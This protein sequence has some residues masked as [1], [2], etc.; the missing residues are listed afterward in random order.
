[1]Q[2]A[3]EI[4]F[5]ELFTEQERIRA[6]TARFNVVHGGHE[7]GKSTLAVDT[8]LTSQYGALNGYP[9]GLFVPDADALLT[10]KRRVFQVVQPL[11]T[12]RL[13]RSRVDLINGGS[14][15]FFSLDAQI[16]ELWDQLALVVV[17]DA[18]LVP[19]IHDIWSDVLEPMLAKHRG[20]AWFFSKPLGVRNGFHEI[21]R[22][23]GSDDRWATFQLRASDNPYLDQT[24]VEADRAAMLPEVFAQERD[25]EFIS[26]PIE[27]SAGQTLIGRDE[28][29]RQW[30]NRLAADGLKV[31]GH[32]FTLDDRPAMWF[33]YDLIPSTIEDAYE[34]MVVMMKCSQVGFTIMELLAQIYMALKFMPA[35]VGLYLP[36]QNLARIKSSQRFVPLLRTIPSAY[37]LMVDPDG[38]S[39]RAGEGNVMIRNLGSSS[40]YFLWTSGKGATESVPLDLLALDEVQ[41]MQV[42]DMEKVSERLSAS[43][44]KFTMAGSTANW[45]D[46]DIHY[47]YQR[48]TMHQFW[49]RCR[50]C[51]VSHV[52]DEHFPECI[53]YDS[54]TLDYRY[55][56]VGCGAWIND[57]Q[58]GEWRNRAGTWDPMRR[59][60]LSDDGEVM[61]ESVH[62]PQ[63]LSTTISARN[64]IEAY[65]NADDM[66]N[67]Y[68]RKLGKPYVDPRQTPITLAALNECARLGMLAGLV[69]KKTAR[70]TF[71]GIDN[72]GGMSCVVIIERMADGRMALVHAEQIHGLNPWARLDD[73]M[74]EYGVVV[75]VCE[76]L[77]NYDSAKQFAARHS[78]KVFLV[79]SYTIIED[80]M[81]RWGD[82]VVTK[83]DRRTAAEYRDR[84][85]VTLD[86]YKMMS[87][88]FGRIQKQM[89]LFPD[90]QALTQQIIDRGEPRTVAIL[91]DVLFEH[92][93]KT[94]LVT[95]TDDDEH[96]MRRKV[97]KI[98]IDPHFS[99]SFMMA[100]SAWCRAY[101]TSSFLLP[102]E[103]RNQ[104]VVALPGA[105]TK[106]HLLN[107]LLV[108]TEAADASTCGGCASFDRQH[109]YCQ[110]REVL[111]RASDAA[112]PL[113]V[114]E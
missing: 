55:V 92:F 16:I 104:D 61:P 65:H 85:T 80:D 114:P 98:G 43:R 12:G 64:I 109:G 101:G 95:M 10:A 7:A 70:R 18:A 87:W 77:P 15:F 25:G 107:R 41:E 94:A 82:A 46:R 31:D 91:K 58:D 3:F 2:T 56:C 96:K 102:D 72:M 51:G 38:A 45:P 4:D 50:S 14:I 52:L 21:A 54:E 63:F 47:L 76:Q 30:C 112:C 68:N 28:T 78:G 66:K 20:H 67:F 103:P 24:K 59:R 27:L 83:N 100:C 86:Q 26:T 108:E 13:D 49:T 48:G 11:L 81:L 106:N 89:I 93:M 75:A 113:Y 36:D 44:I 62:F 1:M 6:S 99:Y 8:L 35:A 105:R 57:A 23:A 32:P 29:F 111:V 74:V 17:D 39:H 73:L 22:L 40:F 19:R 97:L 84:Y 69:W 42:K 53:R 79:A 71:M 37:R 33:I 34:R 9:V 5:P 110:E 60:W 90:P 88:A